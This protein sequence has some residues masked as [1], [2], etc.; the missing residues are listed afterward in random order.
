MHCASCVASVTRALS[1]VAGVEKVQVLLDEGTATL[2][3]RGFSTEQAVEAVRSLGF[4]VATP[5]AA[6]P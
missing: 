6:A 5:T 1:G 2:R 4:E 3:G